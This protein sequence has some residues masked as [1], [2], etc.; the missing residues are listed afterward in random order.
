M[1]TN[2]IT[3]KIGFQIQIQ[4]S[5]IM[6]PGLWNHNKEPPSWFLGCDLMEINDWDMDLSLI[7]HLE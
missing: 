3:K 4:I 1:D 7:F 6:N 5:N 2:I